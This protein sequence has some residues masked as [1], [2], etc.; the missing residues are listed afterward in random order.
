MLNTEAH[1][2]SKDGSSWK[3]KNEKQ[4]LTKFEN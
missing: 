2:Q 3:K 4:K 1:P